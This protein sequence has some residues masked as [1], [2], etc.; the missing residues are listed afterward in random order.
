MKKLLLSIVVFFIATT[1]FAQPPFTRVDVSAT[2]A[3]EAK[4]ISGL[5]ATDR[6]CDI[7]YDYES[8]A[9]W[10]TDRHL[11]TISCSPSL[12]FLTGTQGN[13]SFSGQL[14]LD[15]IQDASMN[16]VYRSF[17]PILGNSFIAEV[18]ARIKNPSNSFIGYFLMALTQF[19]TAPFTD[20]TSSCSSTPTTNNAIILNVDNASNGAPMRISVISKYGSTAVITQTGFVMSS[21]VTYYFRLIRESASKLTFEVFSDAN[22]ANLLFRKSCIDIDPRIAGLKTIQHAN[23]PGGGYLRT[24]TGYIDNVCINANP[25]LTC[26]TPKITGNNTICEETTPAIFQV[27]AVEGNTYTWILP[28]DVTYTANATNSQI[29]ITNWGTVTQIPKQVDIKVKMYCHCDSFIVS[30]P[31]Y[32]YPKRDPSFSIIGLGT[33]GPLLSNF[34]A[35]GNSGATGTIN[36]WEIREWN[37]VSNTEATVNPLRNIVWQTSTLPFG[38]SSA[39]FV[40]LGSAAGAPWPNA[41][42]YSPNVT[43]GNQFLDLQ[44]GKF[45]IIK[46]GMYYEGGTCDWRGSSRVIY[47]GSNLKIINLGEANSAEYKKNLE[48]LRRSEKV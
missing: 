47:I 42:A 31:V 45:Y 9:G 33:S 39:S 35:Q 23:N 19:D 10:N 38:I 40:A 4:A 32:V 43:T 6:R 25:D 17:T 24:A 46:H 1:G 21:D 11:F 29:T 48:I 37:A 12:S 3:I 16:R 2:K 28:S 5:L 14:K 22:R 27:N 8:G 20:F 7:S 30:Y 44:A 34:S 18:E 26:C 36:H 13:H 15:N 41:A